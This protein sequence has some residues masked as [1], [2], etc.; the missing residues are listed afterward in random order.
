M[1]SLLQLYDNYVTNV[2][3][4]DMAASLPV[5]HMIQEY[6]QDGI[7]ILDLGSGISSVALSIATDNFEHTNIVTCDDDVNWL[8]KT[9]Q[10]IE[11]NNLKT[12]EM[13]LWSEFKLKNE[14]NYDLIFYDLGRIPTRLANMKYVFE[15]LAKGGILIV[16]DVHKLSVRT[17]VERLLPLFNYTTIKQTEKDEFGRFALVLKRT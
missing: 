16:D 14:H 8:Q 9:R 12:H 13:V 1:K 5:L 17:E 3:T 2:S 7:N 4:R 10:Y 15:L 6:C 11:N